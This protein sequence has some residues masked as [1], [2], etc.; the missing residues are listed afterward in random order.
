MKLELVQ[1]N[2]FLLKALLTT[3][4]CLASANDAF[5]ESTGCADDQ[6]QSGQNECAVLQMEKAD[7]ALLLIY[8][9]LQ[10]QLEPEQRPILKEVEKSWI[11]YRDKSCDFD[12]FP[13]RNGSMNP[14]VLAT[15]RTRFIEKRTKELEWYLTCSGDAECPQ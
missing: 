9:R 8:Q 14:Y 15:C 13:T 5:P 7:A 10:K 4:F 1:M 6:G 2:H 11:N 3:V 12:A